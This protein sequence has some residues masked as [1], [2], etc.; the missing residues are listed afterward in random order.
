MNTAAQTP[1]AV[2]TP[3][4]PSL[5]TA[6]RLFAGG[7]AGLIAWEMFARGLAPIVLG[8]ALEPPQ[9]IIALVQNWTGLELPGLPALILH[10][11]VGIIAYPLTYW[12]ISRALPRWGTIF[13]AAVWTIFTFAAG[14]M[15]LSGT[16]YAGLA[17]FWLVV[18]ALYTLRFFVASSKLSAAI[19]WG[20]FTWFNALGI[21]A[22]LAGMSF[23]LLEGSA[24]FSTMS[25]AGHVIYGAVAVLVFEKWQAAG[26]DGR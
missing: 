18:S 9:L 1:A 22:P 13:D 21:M 15:F 3:R 24:L 20:S 6:L 23:L 11:C 25:W 8:E 2:A 26:M 5:A 19:S 12:V 17:I 16:G 4:A 10:I 7:V 14:K